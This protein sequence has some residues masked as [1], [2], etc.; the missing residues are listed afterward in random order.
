MKNP[1]VPVVEPPTSKASTLI[2]KPLHQSV[3]EVCSSCAEKSAHWMVKHPSYGSASTPL[4]AL[5]FFRNSGW[6]ATG[7]EQFEVVVAAIGKRRQTPMER[8]VMGMLVNLKDA[9]D[10]LG[11]IVL[12]DRVASFQQRVRRSE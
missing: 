2:L 5:C 3:T 1:L 10:V 11:A 12:N 6:M 9:D 4:C 8:D 7:R